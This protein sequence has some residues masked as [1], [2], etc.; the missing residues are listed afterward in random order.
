MFAA[1]G[2]S[3]HKFLSERVTHRPCEAQKPVQQSLV[4]RLPARWHPVPNSL[5]SYPCLR[6]NLRVEQSSDT[7]EVLRVCAGRFTQ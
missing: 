2:S 1:L 6:W 4:E 5:E 7:L 3:E